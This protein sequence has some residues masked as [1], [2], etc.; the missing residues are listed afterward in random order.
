ML[1]L[2]DL[3]LIEVLFIILEVAMYLKRKHL[4][5]PPQAAALDDLDLCYFTYFSHRMA[6]CPPSYDLSSMSKTL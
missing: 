4:I 6:R 2:S 3:E 5:F 1:V